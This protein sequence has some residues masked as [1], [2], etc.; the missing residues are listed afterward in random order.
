MRNDNLLKKLQEYFK[1][2]KS[3]FTF[4]KNEIAFTEAMKYLDSEALQ[5]T[6]KNG[7]NVEEYEKENGST[8]I[9][10]MYNYSDLLLS[11]LREK[12]P[13]DYIE[14]YCNQFPKVDERE[15]SN[16]A[17]IKLRT[18]LNK[19]VSCM[20]ILY[21]NGASLTRT[22]VNVDKSSFIGVLTAQTENIETLSPFN[23]AIDVL[24]YCKNEDVVNWFI[25]N[26]DFN[27][28]NERIDFSKLIRLDSSLSTI[29]LRKISHRVKL[30]DYRVDTDNSRYSSLHECAIAGGAN[31]K[32]EKMNILYNAATPEQRLRYNEDC[33][34]IQAQSENEV[35]YRK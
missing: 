34:T 1:T 28:S 8:L 3:D 26:K 22:G 4:V 30:T 21:Q 11:L 23:V 33:A 24:D 27:I 5:E 25:N 17:R 32:R 13:K 20:N 2:V 35:K 16:E 9:K 19:L 14:Y 15:L 7:F 29:V 18:T 10:V 12:M 31:T 6:I